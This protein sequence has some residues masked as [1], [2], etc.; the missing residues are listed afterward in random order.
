MQAW[1]VSRH[2]GR[3]PKGNFS[4]IPKTFA[5]GPS[6]AIAPWD[7]PGRSVGPN[8]DLG[9]HS[10]H[11]R[12]NS[13]DLTAGTL[14][15]FDYRRS[16]STVPAGSYDRLM[17]RDCVHRDA[18]R[19]AR[20]A[21][22][23]TLRAA[24]AV[25]DGAL[26]EAFDALRWRGRCDKAAASAVAASGSHASLVAVLKWRRCPPA[27]TRLAAVTDP[28]VHAEGRSAAAW[29]SRRTH[30]QTSLSVTMS[31]HRTAIMVSAAATVDDRQVAAGH[32][33]CPQAALVA[34]ASDDDQRTLTAVARNESSPQAALAS[35]VAHED[36][37]IRSEAASHPGCASVLLTAIV[38]QP[39]NYWTVKAI[40]GHHNCTHATI[41]ALAGNES[42]S[43]RELAARHHLCDPSTL[44]VL[45]VDE[46]E[47]VR[48]AV[49]A[50]QSCDPH[51]LRILSG[52]S[53]NEV[54]AAVA[55]NPSCD[56][57]VVETL[58]ADQHWLVRDSAAAAL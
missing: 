29:A 14:R 5:A 50:N 46:I 3:H 39:S 41:K 25:S 20:S 23:F 40:A 11:D 28:A 33:S 27:V 8:V 15:R 44:R 10:R 51:T 58:A 4:D 48:A 13:D 37:S 35:L 34:F 22:A 31:A 17:A 2:P 24:A 36:R 1:A 47:E 53:D 38:S 7:K 32:R 42:L 49:A 6:A 57:D 21:P 16:V 18:M 54:R 56:R 52:D 19:A 30:E 55:A 45:A 12:I 26:G 9:R 43:A